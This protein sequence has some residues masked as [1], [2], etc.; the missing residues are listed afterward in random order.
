MP[1]VAALRLPHQ[2]L[3]LAGLSLVALLAIAYY[4]LRLPET[5]RLPRLALALVLGGAIVAATLIASSQDD[6]GT[7][8]PA[9]DL[10]DGA[11][12]PLGHSN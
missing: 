2:H 7:S 5:A 8:D 12:D 6:A 3:L 4:F 9:R 11:L 1:D 10:A